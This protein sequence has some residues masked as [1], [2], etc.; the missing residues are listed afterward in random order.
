MSDE[1]SC[2]FLVTGGSGPIGF[3]IGLRLLQL[4]HEV[5]LFDINYPSE[6][7]DSNIRFSSEGNSGEIEEMTCSFGKMKF[8]KG[9][10]FHKFSHHYRQS[11]VYVFVGVFIDSLL[12][13]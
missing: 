10:Y 1:S 11:Q 3:H 4:K 9:N 13:S 5:I 2:R 6:K 7:W 8:V 12:R